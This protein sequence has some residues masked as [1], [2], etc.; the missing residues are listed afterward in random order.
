MKL[1]DVMGLTKYLEPCQPQCVLPPIDSWSA[2]ARS[3][4]KRAHRA[5]PDTLKRGGARK[6]ARKH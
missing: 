2:P 4:L 5:R 1:F 3:W 6:K